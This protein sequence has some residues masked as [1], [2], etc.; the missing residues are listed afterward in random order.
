[1]H[2][3]PPGIGAVVIIIAKQNGAFRQSGSIL[4]LRSGDPTLGHCESRR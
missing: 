4:D 1:M 2:H 3:P